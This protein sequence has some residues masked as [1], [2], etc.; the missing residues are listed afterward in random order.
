[1]LG[2]DFARIL[3]SLARFLNRNISLITPL[4][5]PPVV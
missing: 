1:L 2:V 3:A 5:E 4:A